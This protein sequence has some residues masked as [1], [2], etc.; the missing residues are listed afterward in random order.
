M[1]LRFGVALRPERFDELA[2]QVETAEALG[3]A[4]VGVTESVALARDPWMA[5]VVTAQRTRRVPIGTLVTNPLVR[6]PTALAAAAASLAELAPGRIYIGIASGYSGVY[7]LGM[8]P[9][10][11]AYLE[12]YV[13]AVRGLLEK[14]EAQFQG[15]HLEVSW[16]HASIP[17]YI[18]AHGPKAA[19]LAGR[20]GDGV[21]LGMGVAPEV[22]DS[23]LSLVEAGALEA[24][25]K[26][27][28][29]DVWW[30]CNWFVDPE[31]G[32]AR[33]EAAW[34]VASAAQHLAYQ[35]FKGKL[36][37][38]DLHAPLER[39]AAAYDMRRHG[40]PD[41]AMRQHYIQLAEELGVADYL[42]GR[43]AIAGT[44]EEC[45]AQL[46]RLEEAGATRFTDVVRP[47]DPL[48]VMRRWQELV[49]GPYARTQ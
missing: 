48:G 21:I 44:P 18:A 8:K 4:L 30:N 14:G 42:V 32:R 28:D 37:P 49:I 10:S 24:G 7:N 1:A 26:L 13:H 23:C 20:I 39:L 5:L 16:A 35:G 9:A 19:R 12:A 6:H 43:Y 33:R 47:P 45:M 31:P 40:L 2:P 11:L 46:R 22:V 41:A 3:Y 17:I 15:Q 38:P 27:G 36:V 25:R 34:R 29:L